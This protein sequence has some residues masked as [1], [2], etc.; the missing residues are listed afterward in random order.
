MLCEGK[1]L[2]HVEYQT[3]L[4]SA[5]LCIILKFE[6]ILVLPSHS[7]LHISSVKKNMHICKHD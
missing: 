2:T 7:N 4:Q 3:H 5:V 6:I 1:T